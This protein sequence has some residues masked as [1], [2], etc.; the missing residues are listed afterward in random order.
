MSAPVRIAVAG[1]GLIGKRHVA[2]IAQCQNAVLS[3]VVDPAPN[4]PEFAAS[5]GVPCYVSLQ[6]LFEEDA[7]D[8]VILATPNQ[9]HVSGG[10]ECV[11]NR[12]PFLVEKPLAT[13]AAEASSLVSRAREAKIPILVG[14]HRRHNPLIRKARDIVA[15]GEIGRIRG[16][17]ATC[18]LF[19]PD[20]YFEEATWRKKAGAGPISVNL[21][22]DIDLL[23]FLCGD[24]ISVQAQ[25]SPSLRGYENE[26]V[27]SAL[28]VFESGAV[29]TITVSD[30]IVSPWSWELTANENPAYP[31]TTQSCYVLGG[32]HGSLSLPDLTVWKNGSTRSWWEPISATTVPRGASDPLVNQIAH[33]VRVIR[34]EERPL[35]SGEEGLRTLEVVEA[36]QQA[37]QTGKT[38]GLHR[39]TEDPAGADATPQAG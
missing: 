22:H 16:V 24:I 25:A 21:V 32:T 31:P 34:G 15:E 29:G 12:C 7:P 37:V 26:D 11:A 3:A 23:R 39:R 38:V 36:I 6:A 2:A 20:D 19:K 35:V 5:H 17:H 8:G 14:H 1:A 33:F 4:A 27:A 28:L 13:S 9:I 30:T 10:L 18:W